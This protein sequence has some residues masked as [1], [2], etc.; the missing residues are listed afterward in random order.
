MNRLLGALTGCIL[1]GGCTHA[2]WHPNQGWAASQSE[3]VTVF[4]DALVEHEFSQEWLE[5]SHAAYRAFLPGVKRDKVDVVW[6]KSEPGWASRVY[7]PTDIPRS[8]WTLESLPGGGPIGRDG[9]IV[10]ETRDANAAA[11]QMAHLFIE[12]AVP[13]AA[14]WLHVGLAHYM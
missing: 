13:K 7:G 5:L 9:L 11:T 8:A 1:V 12:S 3:H 4:T 2:P 14:L 6:L 10:L